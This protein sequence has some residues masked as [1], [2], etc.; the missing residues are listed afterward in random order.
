MVC[1]H[2]QSAER[3]SA[4]FGVHQDRSRGELNAVLC[5]QEDMGAA[6]MFPSSYVSWDA[7]CLCFSWF[8]SL[9]QE[10]KKTS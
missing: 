5:L 6:E 2:S 8:H 9:A 3:S 4:E 10:K 7:P 1:A